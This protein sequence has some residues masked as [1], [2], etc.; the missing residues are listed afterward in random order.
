MGKGKGFALWKA[1][2]LGVVRHPLVVILEVAGHGIGGGVVVLW[3][4]L[5]VVVFFREGKGKVEALEFVVVSMER[6]EEEE[7]EVG[8]VVVVVVEM[9][10]V[11]D[12]G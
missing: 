1:A 5:M 4:V 7:V 11:C 9:K 6:E 10:R 3:R 2:G 12:G 8:V